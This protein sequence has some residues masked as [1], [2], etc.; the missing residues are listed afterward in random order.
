[1]LSAITLLLPAL[2]VPGVTPVGVSTLSYTEPPVRLWMSGDRRFEP[3]DRA[4]VQVEARDDG[5]LLVLHYDTDG[6]V[7]VLFPLEPRDDAF[8]RGGRRYEVRDYSSRESFTVGMGGSGFVYV[9]L[10]PDPWDLR[11]WSRGA[12]W[13]YDRIAVDYDTDDPERDLTALLERISGPRGFDYDLLEYYVHE[14][15]VVRY[16]Y[17]PSR[18]YTPGVWFSDPWCDPYWSTGWFCASRPGVVINYGRFYRGGWWSVGYGP[19]WY[20]PSSTWYWYRPYAYGRGYHL[21]YYRPWVWS[22]PIWRPITDRPVIIGRSRDYTTGRLSPWTFDRPAAS[23]PRPAPAL[24]D[25]YR[26]TEGGITRSRPVT[27]SRPAPEASRGR[28]VTERA[29]PPA[30]AG[31]SRPESSRPAASQPA[32][33]RAGDDNAPAARPAQDRQPP[34]PARSRPRGNDDQPAG[35][36]PAARTSE[37]TRPA[38]ESPRSAPPPARSRP[39]APESRGDAAARQAPAERVVPQREASRSPAPPP[40]TSRAAPPAA[41]PQSAP[42]RPESPERRPAPARSRGQN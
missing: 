30:S 21:R 19:S 8:V 35:S 29:A 3:G 27:G 40:Q 23:A 37:P 36:A 20:W 12:H 1:M 25:A 13:D 24:G 34:A 38:A 6:R 2:A 18:Y 5:Y 42:A 10:A 28:P 32:G 17:R 7:R 11:L 31:R 15:E 33:R 4:R 26:P 41:R 9:A 16:E 39:V 22:G 14:V